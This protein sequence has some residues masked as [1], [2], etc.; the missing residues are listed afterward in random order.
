[1]AAVRPE[2]RDVCSDAF[3]ISFS[4][5]LYLIL[6]VGE[7]NHRPSKKIVYLSYCDD[8][9][10]LLFFSGE[11]GVRVLGQVPGLVAKRLINY[12]WSSQNVGTIALRRRGPN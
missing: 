5:K 8:A 3:N 10:N 1:M 11:E 9:E 12:L 6:I 7:L 4:T 2:G